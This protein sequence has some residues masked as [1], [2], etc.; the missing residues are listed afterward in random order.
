MEDRSEDE[1]APIQLEIPQG[2]PAAQIG[3]DLEAVGL[4]Q[5]ANAWELWA[6][7][8]RWRQP[9]GSFQAGVYRF[10][11]Q[12]SMLEIGAQIWDGEVANQSFTIPEG[13]SRLEMANYFERR[14]V[15]L[16]RGLS[17]SHPGN[18]PRS[19]PLAPR[20]YSSFGGLPLS[21]YLSGGG[22]NDYP[23]WDYCPDVRSV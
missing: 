8:L 12:E 22:R 9:E 21:R 2:T 11:P 5:S 7:W 17:R 4:I 13:W 23:R 6:R 18:S 10:S 14:E 19:L 1:L 16:G 15:F 3:R 20:R